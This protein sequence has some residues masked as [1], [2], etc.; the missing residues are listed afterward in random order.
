MPPRPNRGFHKVR[1][2]VPILSALFA[3]ATG[4]GAF[5]GDETPTIGLASIKSA[6]VDISH[7]AGI[8]SISLVAEITLPGGPKCPP[9]LAADFAITVNGTHM[10][11]SLFEDSDA[12]TFSCTIHELDGSATLVDTGGPLHVELTQG[13]RKASMVIA[14]SAFPAIGPVAVSRTAVPAGESF[15]MSVAVSGA[16]VSDARQLAV[17]GDWVASLCVPSGCVPGEGWIGMPPTN[18]G[19]REGGLG[20]DF[21]VPDAVAKGKWLLGLHL[22]QGMFHPAITECSGLPSCTAYNHAEQTF[23][24]GPFDFDVL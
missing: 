12:I 3:S 23:D 13:D 6:Q 15:S 17:S 14:R 9:P 2:L 10:Q 4:C 20:F 21:V 22:F 1:Y 11:L 24:F 18:P 5:G 19:S 16:D 7:N 8:L